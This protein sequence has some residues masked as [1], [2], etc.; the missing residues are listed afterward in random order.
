VR[1]A[2]RWI[3]AKI[4]YFFLARALVL[5][6]LHGCDLPYDVLVRLRDD[7]NRRNIQWCNAFIN[8]SPFHELL[9]THKRACLGREWV[10]EERREEA[11]GML[12]LEDCPV[13][14]YR[15]R[16]QNNEIQNSLTFVP[17]LSPLTVLSP[18]PRRPLGTLRFDELCRKVTT[19]ITNL[20]CH[21][22]TPGS[23]L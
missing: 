22:Y 17:H 20:L 9:S 3:L 6:L 16:P 8:S 12:N 19:S 23:T 15:E 18:L 2:V 21:L 11:A 5:P 4:C 7:C 10:W 14:V 13:R 1:T